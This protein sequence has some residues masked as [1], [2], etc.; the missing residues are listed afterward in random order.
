M[1]PNEPGGFAVNLRTGEIHK[2]HAWHAVNHRR[3]TAAGAEAL[4]HGRMPKLCS[5][6]FPPPP[7]TSTRFV[8]EPVKVIEP[9]PKRK[10]KEETRFDPSVLYEEVWKDEEPDVTTEEEPDGANEPD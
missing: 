2:R 8:A 7:K 5:D 9:K 3:T 1:L 6:C 4:L 10:A